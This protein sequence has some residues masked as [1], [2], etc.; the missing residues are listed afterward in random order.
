M[1]LNMP[2]GESHTGS[3]SLKRLKAAIPILKQRIDELQAIDVDVIQEH[4]EARLDAIE[5][6][7][8]STLEDIFGSDTI[9]YH[10]HRVILDTASKSILYPTPIQEIREGYKRGIDLATG[11]LKRII[12]L[13]EDKVGDLAM[14]GSTFGSALRAF[15]DLDIHP[16][17]LQ[18]TSELLQNGYYQQAAEEACRT[19]DGLVK[20]RSGK[21][22]LDGAEL[23]QQVFNEKT[24]ILRFNKQET[25]SERRKQKEMMCLYSGAMFVLSNPGAHEL[26]EDDPERSLEYIAFISLLAKSLDKSELAEDVEL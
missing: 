23:M 12:K 24:P 15:H 9:E 2:S 25:E 10:L 22:E 11:N 8:D 26:L 14:A 20:E 16:T 21:H 7:I 3:I 17:I 19:F 5:Q 1:A 18:A 4:N 6:K 13:L